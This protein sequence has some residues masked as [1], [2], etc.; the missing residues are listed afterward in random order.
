M[1]S[2]SQAARS[3]HFL[4]V[5][6][7]AH[8]SQHTVSPS[9]FLSLRSTILGLPYALAR[10]QSLPFSG[11]ES[12]SKHHPKVFCCQ[13]RLF[14]PQIFCPPC[15]NENMK[16]YSIAFNNFDWCGLC[17]AHCRCACSTRSCALGPTSTGRQQSTLW[18]WAERR[19]P[20][21]ASKRT[22]EHHRKGLGPRTT[23]LYHRTTKRIISRDTTRL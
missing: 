22:R 8:L 13:M 23:A 3:S 5:P 9:S 16:P 12:I 10:P 1:H 14:G 20:T 6:H 11:I 21:P 19:P 7:P 17:T 18:H 4:I 2:T 15:L